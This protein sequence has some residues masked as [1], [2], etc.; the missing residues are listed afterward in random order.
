M[1]LRKSPNSTNKKT[2]KS[3]QGQWPYKTFVSSRSCRLCGQ[4]GRNWEGQVARVHS[5][6]SEQQGSGRPV[7]G[8]KAGAAGNDGIHAKSGAGNRIWGVSAFVT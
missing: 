4:V 2:W 7:Y 6:P 5:G 1:N 3:F 8:K